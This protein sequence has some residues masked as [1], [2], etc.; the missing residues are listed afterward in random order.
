MLGCISFTNE[1]CCSKI[2]IQVED[3]KKVAFGFQYLSSLRSLQSTFHLREIL[4]ERIV[5]LGKGGRVV[6]PAFYF[7]PDTINNYSSSIGRG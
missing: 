6:F 5:G 4:T 7:H 3:E 2:N 1:C